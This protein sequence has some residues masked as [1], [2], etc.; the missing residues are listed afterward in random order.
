MNTFG[1][2]ALAAVVLA[3]LLGSGW[4]A[5]QHRDT[6]RTSPSALSSGSAA[7]GVI[8]ATASRDSDVLREVNTTVRL[9]SDMAVTYGNLASAIA[10]IDL[11]QQRIAREPSQEAWAE[12]RKSLAADRQALAMFAQR[13][14]PAMAAQI[15]TIVAD[16]DRLPLIS[17]PRPLTQAPRSTAPAAPSNGAGAWWQSIWSGIQARFFEVVQIRRVEN[18]DALFLTPEQ[19][20]LVAERLRLRL[21]SARVALMSRQDRLLQHDLEQSIVILRQAYDRE[22]AAVRDHLQALETLAKASQGLRPVGPLASV[23]ILSAWSRPAS[24]PAPEGKS[25]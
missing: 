7:S 2:T 23:A 15:E 13:D 16:I 11:A 6:G 25:P 1:K 8:S 3:A 17:A 9:A 21:L 22:H 14:I 18:A 19:G 10:L 5:I 12:L 20:A 4:W 24:V